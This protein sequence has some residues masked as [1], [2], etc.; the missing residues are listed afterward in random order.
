M[1]THN[2][3]MAWRNL[4]KYRVQSIISIVGLA[5][6]FTAFSFT[7][8]WINYQQSY[9]AHI[10]DKDRI[11]L[12]IQD[13]SVGSVIGDVSH[14]QMPLANYLEQNFPE[15]E[16]ATA[17]RTYPQTFKL[18]DRDS[19]IDAD[20]A[21]VDSS[22]FKVFYPQWQSRAPKAYT[23]GQTN[24]FL[25]DK[26]I[27]VRNINT[28]DLKI[29]FMGGLPDV[30]VHTNVPFQVLQ[31]A[32]RLCDTNDPGQWCSW[33]NFT[34]IKLRPGV[35]MDVLIKKLNKIPKQYEYANEPKVIAVPL[36]AVY[37]TIP[38]VGTTVKINHLR[39]FAIVSFMV[40]LGAI[41]NFLMLFI[42]R[43][44]LRSR[45]LALR[46]AN[47]AGTAQ[48]LIYLMTEYF[49]LIVLSLFMGLV[50]S[51]L[52]FHPFSKFSL[53]TAPRSYF[54]LYSLLYAL[55]LVVLSLGIAL[56]PVRHFMQSSI[57][58]NLKPSSAPN[59]MKYNFTMTC[60]WL[61]LTMS[62]LLIFCTTVLML[63]VRWLNDSNEAGFDRSGIHTVMNMG[64]EDKIHVDELKSIPG[65]ERVIHFPQSF[66]PQTSW[67][68]FTEDDS[69]GPEGGG[70]PKTYQIFNMGSPEDFVPFFN[71][72][73]L[74]G[75]NLH[76]GEKGVCLINQA[77]CK[78]LGAKHPLGKT[79]NKLTI[80]GIVQ[81]L[82]TSLPTEPVKPTMFV[83]NAQGMGS[84]S[85]TLA[86]KCDAKNAIRIEKQIR[87]TLTKTM[88]GNRFDLSFY[89]MEKQYA[90][91][92]RSERNLLRLL[93]V[94]TGI[95]ILIAVFGI[96]S[97]ITLS[98]NQRRKEIAIR[99]V[100]GA[101]VHEIM[102]LFIRQYVDIVLLSCAVSFPIGYFIMS[103]WVEQY[104]RQVSIRWYIYVI[105]LIAINLLVYT[106]IVSR[107]LKAAYQNPANVL[108]SE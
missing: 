67:C 20:I 78:Q 48:L 91:Y 72:K 103:R 84:L 101:G 10:Q 31:M 21:S 69:D 60:L 66:L 15:I 79:L 23:K 106:C 57:Q 53:I 17:L 65:I 61:Q 28:H 16:A 6:G 43:I 86:Y 35:K 36:R 47:G 33:G 100:N 89:D 42:N 108:K 12:L 19:I 82:Y 68:S 9:D 38:N 74:E 70:S 32:P 22:F 45:E 37:T 99:K 13:K 73:I 40:T 2:L 14:T 83:T 58:S 88:V 105:I 51:E 46:R 39:I 59:G 75:R 54:M 85:G 50:L 102:R 81:D 95:A 93:A 30:G 56:L 24:Y 98:C 52:L 25:S 27:S 3:S 77:A 107:V 76:N 11:Y 49:M 94:M 92:T 104:S 63:Q 5:I 41:F 34:Y 87:K 96:Y 90:T 62:V 18:N 29:G 1:F 8:S 26:L 44:R 97:M 4:R 71:V 80:V 7:L 64:D 55:L